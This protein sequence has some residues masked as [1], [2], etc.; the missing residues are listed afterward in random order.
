M[1]GLLLMIN[2]NEMPD[3]RS[4]L[5]AIFTLVFTDFPRFSVVALFGY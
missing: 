3:K 1:S 5:L 2:I 4:I